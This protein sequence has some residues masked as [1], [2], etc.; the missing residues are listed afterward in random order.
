MPQSAATTPINN[1]LDTR[2]E[3]I[4]DKAGR[5]RFI[6]MPTRLYRQHPQ[7]TAPLFIERYLHLSDHNPYFKHAR[8]Q[9]WLATRNGEP[10]GR[11]SAQIDQSRLDRYNDATAYFG[12]LD[13]VDD[14]AVFQALLATATDWLA[15]QGI[16]RV[17][18]PFNFSTNHD[19]GLL[20]DGFDTP[21]AVMM[22]HN[23]PYYAEQMLMAG[24]EPV[25]DLLAY[26]IDA[27]FTGPRAMQA[28][29]D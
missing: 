19:C 18:G 7:W 21:P 26:N 4:A 9:S 28:L 22:P 14:S 5:R 12:F 13:A 29:I 27:D 2:I 24:F 20:V 23:P 3:A 10:V 11:I 1:M 6:N 16:R 25:Q 15:K 8:W 17:R